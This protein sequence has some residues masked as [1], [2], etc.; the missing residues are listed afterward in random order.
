VCRLRALTRKELIGRD[1]AAAELRRKQAERAGDVTMR[2]A[3]DGMAELRVFLPAPLAAPIKEAIDTYARM[4]KEN[5]DPR[6]IGQLRVG[7]LADLVLRPWDTSRPPV[8]AHVTV[9][10]PL[11]TLIGP[12]GAP[13]EP[14]CRPHSVGPSTSRSSNRRPERCGRP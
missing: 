8:T 11:P 9:V 3:P 2:R 12:V 14:G 6:P 10:A 4:A 1:A 7:V 13:A 5:G